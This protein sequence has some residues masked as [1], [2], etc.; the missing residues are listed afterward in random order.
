[1][2]SFWDY[3]CRYRFCELCWIAGSLTRIFNEEGVRGLYRGL[4][5]TLVALIP[6]WTVYFTVYDRLKAAI[7]S[8]A[9]GVSPYS[10]CIQRRQ[11]F[12][13]DD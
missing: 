13:R 3:A 4:M 11:V 10:P 6:N 5:P 2:V 8:H 7:G 1:M 9:K 12:S